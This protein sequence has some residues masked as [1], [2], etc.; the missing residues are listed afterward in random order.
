MQISVGTRL[1]EVRDCRECLQVVLS[2][3]LTVPMSCGAPGVQSESGTASAHAFTS[4]IN[5]AMKCAWM[6]LH[7]ISKGTEFVNEH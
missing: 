7:V 1:C 6:L 4:D 3:Q 5:M 2:R